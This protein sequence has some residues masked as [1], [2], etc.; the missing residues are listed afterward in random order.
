M[1]ILIGCWILFIIYL[2]LKGDIGHFDISMQIRST[3]WYIRNIVTFLNFQIVQ[4]LTL[5]AF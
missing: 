5:K 4:F 2:N 3:L 1:E